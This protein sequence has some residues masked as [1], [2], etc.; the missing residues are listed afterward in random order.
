MQRVGEVPVDGEERSGCIAYLLFAIFSV[1]SSLVIGT[2]INQSI[3]AFD[4]F[5]LLRKAYICHQGTE[6]RRFTK[7]K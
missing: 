6:A 7:S 1:I 3:F 2:T 4:F 5:K